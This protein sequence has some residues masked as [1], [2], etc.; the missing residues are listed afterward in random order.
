[1]KT[2]GI[3]ELKQNASAVV[4]EAAA[5]ETVRITSRGRAVAQL[6]PLPGSPLSGMLGSGRARP[7]R[8]KISSLGPPLTRRPGAPVLSEVLAEMRDAERH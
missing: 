1:M 8:R 4:A 7:A 5:G 6:V 2:V 3:R